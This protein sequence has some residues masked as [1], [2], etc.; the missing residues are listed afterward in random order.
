MNTVINAVRTSYILQPCDQLINKRFHG[1]MSVVR[2]EFNRQG[3]LDTTRLNF[4]LACPIYSC[5]IIT[6]KLE[7]ASF[8]VPGTFQFKWNFAEKFK[9]YEDEQA[10]RMKE[11]KERVENA[12]IASPLVSLRKRHSDQNVFTRTM[13]I[14][15][16]SKG[17]SSKI[18]EKK[19]SYRKKRLLTAF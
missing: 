6:P 7:Q 15:A 11:K 4:A 3:C 8:K 9:T 18:R 12:T 10:D 5:Q 13:D 14:I 16:E 2:D 1:L 17:V 19:F